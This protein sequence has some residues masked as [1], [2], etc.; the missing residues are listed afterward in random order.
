[1]IGGLIGAI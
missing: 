1:V